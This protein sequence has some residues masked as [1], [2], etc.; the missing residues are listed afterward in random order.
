MKMSEKNKKTLRACPVCA[1]EMA[2]VL[3]SQD[4]ILPEGNPLPRNY[5]VVCCVKCGFVYADTPGTQVVYDR[6][7]KDFSKYEEKT[8]ATGGGNTPLDAERLMRTA[9]DIEASISR[10][11]SLIVDIGCANGGLLAALSKKGFTRLAGADPSAV[12]VKAVAGLGF[13]AYA[14]G[15]FDRKWIDEEGLRGK[16]DVVILSH[17]LEHVRDLK[18]ALEN[19]NSLLKEGGYL[20]AEVPDAARYPNYFVVPYYYFDCEHINHF[21]A[22]SLCAL[23][24]RAGFSEVKT[25]AKTLTVSADTLYPALFSIFKKDN[26]AVAGVKAPSTVVRESVMKFIALSASEWPDLKKLAESGEEIA[27]WGAGQYVLRLLTDSPLKDCRIAFFVDKDSK[28]HGQKINGVS[29]ASPEVLRNFEGRIVVCAALHSRE[30]LAEIRN[31][32]LKNEVTLLG[33]TKH[34]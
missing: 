27:V 34:E 13:K 22:A 14:A 28:K 23:M 17:V 31:L 16:F 15:L 32:G 5:D 9:A 12:C 4:F 20:Y 11:D 2:E 19:V 24:A 25:Q 1:N 8:L 7:Y 21:D 33:Q 10:K 29:V 6:Y 18:C 3:H 26:G 30:I